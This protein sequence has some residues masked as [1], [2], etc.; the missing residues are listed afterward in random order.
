MHWSCRAVLLLRVKLLNEIWLNQ[1]L[2]WKLLAVLKLFTLFFF[3]TI[4]Y[5]HYDGR[6]EHGKGL[7]EK[8]MSFGLIEVLGMVLKSMCGCL[9]EGEFG[10]LRFLF[11]HWLWGWFAQ[12]GQT[13][14]VFTGFWEVLIFHFSMEYYNKEYQNG[15]TSNIINL[16]FNFVALNLSLLLWLMQRK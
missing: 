15:N 7:I 1:V 12:R 11:K 5:V 14:I 3:H 10:R 4:R 9:F 2:L 16:T 6:R 8:I 13:A